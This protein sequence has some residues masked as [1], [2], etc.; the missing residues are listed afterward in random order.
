MADHAGRRLELT[1]LQMARSD[2]LSYQVGMDAN[3][4]P[5]LHHRIIASALMELEA[6]RIDRLMIEAPPRHG[7]TRQIGVDFPSWYM[8]R[9]PERNVGYCTYN[10]ERAGDVGFFVRENFASP[11]HR[12]CFPSALIDPRSSSSTR[13]D[14]R[15]IAYAG[16]Q[17]RMA[18]GYRAVGVGGSL[19]GRGFDL[20]AFD[21][22]VKDRQ[23][24]DSVAFQNRLKNWFSAVAYTRLEGQAAMV[25]MMCM[26]GDTM[27]LLADGSTRKIR[28]I[29]P[30]EAIA[31]Y[32]NGILEASVIERW[33][34]QGVDEVFDIVTS[35]GAQTRAN[36]RHPFLV[37]RN[38]EKQW[39]RLAQLKIGDRMVRLSAAH[40][41]GWCVSKMDVIDSQNQRIDA[42]G[43]TRGGVSAMACQRHPHLTGRVH[44]LR[45]SSIGTASPKSSTTRWKRIKVVA[46]RYASSLLAIISG[47]TGAASSALT[48][49]TQRVVSA[50]FYATIATS[51]SGMGKAQKSSCK[52]PRTFDFTVEAIESITPGGFEE[53]FDVQ[54]ART[55][56]FIAD[57]FVSHNTRWGDMDLHGHI[58]REHGDD[59]WVIIR[60][61]ATAEAGDFL[62]R[63]RGEP[64]WPERWPLD[65]LERIR[66]GLLPRDWMALYRQA[67]TDLEGLYF[68]KDW[69]AW[70]DIAPAKLNVYL[71]GDYAVT[72]DQKADFTEM[73][74]WGID[75]SGHIWL[76]DGWF[77]Q[78]ESH[79]WSAEEVKLIRAHKPRLAFKE[80]GVIRR[81][82][83]PLLKVLRK[84]EHLPYCKTIW[85]PAVADKAA[86]ATSF[87]ARCAM[88]M[89]HFPRNAM[90]RRLA[91]QLCAFPT[92]Q[93]DD[94]VDACGL[95]GRG[96]DLMMRAEARDGRVNTPGIRPFSKEWLE[97]VER[98]A[99]A[100]RDT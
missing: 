8:G 85:L 32:D 16:Q 12:R 1:P 23:Q 9:H 15:K 21:D 38:G 54:V 25:S 48:M 14:L 68:R 87:Q 88:G 34:S 95:L 44:G 13:F 4:R 35:S 90:G 29:R 24:A 66:R 2:L 59:G 56:N 97:Y 99:D 26:A 83:E 17:A 92:G 42:I 72:E 30:G 61:P 46:A 67:P 39:I 62:D 69:F 41:Q 57:G 82:T 18:G 33:S 63:P 84:D 74:V 19:T 100:K 3:Y 36:A 89:V 22:T 6:G 53:V 73:Y 51:Q 70:Y 81:A 49:T 65:K 45:E 50:D 27:V 98:D 20:L 79:I 93:H 40:T 75:A 64:L 58:Q 94:G 96:V 91:D 80:G 43:V 55:E 28:D 86:N 5:G 47:R 10:R 7:K 37:E 31:T 60:L 78:K 11:F 76:L 52:H 77:G 71:T